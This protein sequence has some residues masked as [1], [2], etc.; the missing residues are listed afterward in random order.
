MFSDSEFSRSELQEWL[1][2][3]CTLE[4]QQ[5]LKE[6]YDTIVDMWANGAF[7][8]ESSDGTA[9]ANAEAL[10]RVKAISAFLDMMEEIKE[11]SSDV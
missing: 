10:G 1:N 7:T 9:Q 4:L 6:E 3:Q 5:R 11:S 2:H 8:N